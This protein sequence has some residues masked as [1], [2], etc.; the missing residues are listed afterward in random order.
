MTSYIRDFFD[1][2]YWRNQRIISFARKVQPWQYVAPTTCPFGSLHGTLTHVAMVEWLWRQRLSVG[3]SPTS[4]PDKA[5]FATLDMIVEWWA[6]EERDM[7]AFVNGLS[8]ADLSSTRTYTLLG[9]TPKPVTDNLALALMH[10][11]NHGTQHA[12]EMAQML[13]DYGMSPGNID[14]IYWLRERP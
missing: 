2:N 9:G 10:V 14:V 8:D 7:R 5:Q 1:Y 6:G 4:M 13:T 12:G 3:V 11:V